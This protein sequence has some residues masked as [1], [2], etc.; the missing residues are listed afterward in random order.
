MGVRSYQSGDDPCIN[1]LF[2][3]V[4]STKPSVTEWREKYRKESDREPVILVYEQAGQIIGHVALT[5]RKTYIHGKEQL[6]G[7]RQDRLIDPYASQVHIEKQLHD[8][9]VIKAK[10]L[11]VVCIVDIPACKKRQM[12]E[13]GLETKPIQRYLK[14]N[15]PF[16]LLRHICF[17]S[18][19]SKAAYL[20]KLQET[21]REYNQGLPTGW[22]IG[23]WQEDDP[24]LFQ[25]IAMKSKWKA[26]QTNKADQILRWKDNQDDTKQYLILTLTYHQEIK[27]YVVFRLS[28][29]G[30][31][32]KACIVDLAAID[33]AYTWKLLLTAVKRIL[34]RMHIIQ[35]W[36]CPDATIDH[37]LRK[38]GMRK[39]LQPLSLSVQPLED[40]IR[41]IPNQ[42]WWLVMGDTDQ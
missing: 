41:Q 2:Y 12:P 37:Y 38:I 7:F 22:H 33:E 3:Q 13:T 6:I 23:E 8:Q 18:K 4:C 16:S 17:Q 19:I 26:M 25:F 27:G 42:K 40:H 32:T 30:R 39:W 29:K 11:G 35:F 10:S 1:Q 14:I 21:M 24:A 34:K 36:M 20:T 28:F 31:L 5:L 15:R 9:L